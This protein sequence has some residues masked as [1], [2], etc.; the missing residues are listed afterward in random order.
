MTSK[1]LSL[2]LMTLIVAI[3]CCGG[4]RCTFAGEDLEKVRAARLPL[5]EKGN[6][7]EYTGRWRLKLPAGFEYNLEIKQLDNGLLRVTCPGHALLLLGDFVCVGTELQLVEPRKARIDDYIW[8]Y[9]DGKFILT[10]DEQ[11]HGGHYRG[12]TLTRLQE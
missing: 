2:V 10:K 1:R 3:C 8:S 7:S 12:A 11:Q 6:A 5:N 4:P 9:R